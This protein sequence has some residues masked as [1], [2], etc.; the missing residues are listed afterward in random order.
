M[1]FLDFAT[2]LTWDNISQPDGGP[3]HA[4]CN[5]EGVG[6]FSKRGSCYGNLCYSWV[7]EAIDMQCCNTQGKTYHPSRPHRDAP[8]FG[9]H[10][11]MRAM[12]L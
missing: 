12:L 10:W 7:S 2:L 1:G 4:L 3:Y 8:A 11:C 9:S 5:L 6:M